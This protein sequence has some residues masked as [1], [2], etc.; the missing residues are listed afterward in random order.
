M[1]HCNYWEASIGTMAKNTSVA[2]VPAH[3]NEGDHA[4]RKKSDHL[5][6]AV[7]SK[8]RF[9]K[10]GRHQV[11]HMLACFFYILVIVLIQLVDCRHHD[12]NNVINFSN[13]MP[14]LSFHPIHKSQLSQFVQQLM[15]LYVRNSLTLRRGG[16]A[17]IGII[18]FWTDSTYN[19]KIIGATPSTVHVDCCAIVLLLQNELLQTHTQT[20]ISVH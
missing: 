19:G 13:S 15:S 1:E 20:H 8:Q 3:S 12:L 2:I 4:Q 10:G 6:N 7:A 9:Y 14:F 11:G 16:S 17:T 5:K 18:S